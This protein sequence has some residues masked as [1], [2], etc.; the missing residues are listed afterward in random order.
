[1]TPM[2]E[3]LYSMSQNCK[4]ECCFG[5]QGQLNSA[6]SWNL[7]SLNAVKSE[8][9]VMIS[10]SVCVASDSGELSTCTMPFSH[11]KSSSAIFTQFSKG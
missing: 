5:G 11:F 1:M 7:H 6:Q 8:L 2:S 10:S 3:R 4:A 9:F